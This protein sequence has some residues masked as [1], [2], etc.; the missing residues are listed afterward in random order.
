VAEYF[1]S[2][3]D[4]RFLEAIELAQEVLQFFQEQKDVFKFRNLDCFVDNANPGFISLLKT[5]ARRQGKD[6]FYARA[7]KKRRIE[8]RIS[9]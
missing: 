5:E 2:N 1:H 8:T 6:W 9:W 7:C 4:Q 3:K